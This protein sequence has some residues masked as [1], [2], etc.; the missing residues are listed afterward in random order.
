MK[1]I[2]EI[3]WETKSRR[4]KQNLSE[5]KDQRH[6]RRTSQTLGYPIWCHS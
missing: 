6:I 3:L 5:P 1:T 4:L 2:E